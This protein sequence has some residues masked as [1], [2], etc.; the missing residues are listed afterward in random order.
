MHSFSTGLDAQLQSI[1]NKHY[2]ARLL[3]KYSLTNTR[4]QLKI[5]DKSQLKCIFCLDFTQPTAPVSAPALL[6]RLRSNSGWHIRQADDSRH[7]GK[8]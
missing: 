8:E 2:D 7:P 3:C 4:I 1:L 5:I 6:R